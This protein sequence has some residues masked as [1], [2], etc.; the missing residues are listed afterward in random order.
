MDDIQQQPGQQSAAQEKVISRE[1]PIVPTERTAFINEW[2]KKIEETKEYWRPKF[3]QMRRAQRFARGAQWQDQSDETTDASKKYIANIT[4]RHINSRVA[5]LYARNPK[6]VAKRRPRLEFKMWDGDPESFLWAQKAGM[7]PPPA[8]AAAAAQAGVPPPTPDPAA[9]A[10]LQDIA[11]GKQRIQLYNRIART[12]EYMFHYALEEPQPRFKLQAK[13]LVRRVLTCGIGYVKVGYQRHLNKSPDIE[14]RLKDFTDRMASMQQISA[15]VADGQTTADSAEMESLRVMVADLKNQMQQVVKEGVV[16]DFPQ[17]WSVF[18]DPGVRN[19]KGFVGARWIAREYLFTKEQVQQIYKIDVGTHYTAYTPQGNVTDKRRKREE[20]MCAVYEVYDLEKRVTFTVCL[21]Y[22]DYLKEPVTPELY[23]DQ[24]HPFFALT[25]NDIED[26][27]DVYPPS[28]VELIAPMQLEYNRAREQWRVHRVAARPAWVAAKGVFGRDD[29]DKLATHEQQ[30][31]LELN[32]KPGDDISKVLQAKPLAQIDMKLYETENVFNDV[33][34]VSG[35][36]EANLGGTSEA[37]ATE[38]TVAENTRVSALQSNVDDL[39]EFLSDVSDAAGKVMLLNMS[40]ETVTNIAGPGAVWPELDR[41]AV[42]DN[43]FLEIKA[44][45]S[46]RPNKG[47]AV[48]TI[49]KI[50]PLVMQAPGLNTNW[51]LRYLLTNMDDSIEIEEAILEGAPSITALNNEQPMQAGGAPGNSPTMQGQNGT[52][53]AALPTESPEM[54]RGDFPGNTSQ[55]QPQ[56]L[57]QQ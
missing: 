43:L 33:M 27:E 37:T 45:S 13:S 4:L 6:A 8:A 54:V 15:D 1:T 5:A 55:G 41:Q 11:E 17:P 38:T 56:Q 35:D 31:L 10:M 9:V 7:P 18:A 32:M 22:S 51:W 28:N 48:A 2:T 24:F 20:K 42:A 34:R 57:E 25:F 40:K 26:D 3:D 36:Q 46:G 53:N 19:L 50:A 14:S 16:F 21:G 23:F 52:N 29:K 30:E 49:Q 39:D 12:L 47:L 44:G